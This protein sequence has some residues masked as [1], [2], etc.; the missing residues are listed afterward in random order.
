MYAIVGFS[1][2][3]I[4]DLAFLHEVIAQTSALDSPFANALKE[5]V[6]SRLWRLQS[7][8]R[9]GSKTV[10]YEQMLLHS[11]QTSKGKTVITITLN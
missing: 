4:H 9:E 11:N 3:I 7:A 10:G 2:I 5:W 6:K 8:A 1:F